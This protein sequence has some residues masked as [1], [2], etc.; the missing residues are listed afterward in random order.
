MCDKINDQVVE[1]NSRTTRDTLQISLVIKRKL[2]ANAIR[3]RLPS[4][5]SPFEDDSNSTGF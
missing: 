1:Q 5:N 3:P 4:N 2:V